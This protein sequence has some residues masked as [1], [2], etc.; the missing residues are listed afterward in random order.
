MSKISY[1][2]K[3]YGVKYDSK[4]E[5]DYITVDNQILYV[6]DEKVLN[7]Q[8]GTKAEVYPFLLNDAKNVIK[9]F[10]EK[11]MWQSY[12]WFVIGCN[13]GRRAG[14]T[15]TLTWQHF[16]LTNG[17]FRKELLSIRE[18]K[19]DKFASPYINE[20]VKQA[21]KLYC[22]ELGINPMEEYTEYVLLNRS[23]THKGNLFTIKAYGESIKKAAESCGITYNVNTHSTRKFLG[24]TLI[25]LHPN[26]PRALMIVSKIFGHST[27]EQTMDYVG[28]THEK[29]NDY[30][31][32]MGKFFSEYAEG[33]KE[34]VNSSN[35]NVVSL[36]MNDLRDALTEAYKL[37]LK[38]SDCDTESHIGFINNIMK[39]IEEKIKR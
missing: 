28:I 29:V 18:E 39:A 1:R 9:Y 38:N 26:D 4:M 2:G 36:D 25:D 27:L 19:T 20:A 15:R 7:K 33:D 13:M 30:F 10:K 37:G 3:E 23:G 6:R 12:L 34:I 14:D 22:S 16:F 17:H 31:E 8:P 24:K 5:Y 11:K 35:S 32:D 21:I